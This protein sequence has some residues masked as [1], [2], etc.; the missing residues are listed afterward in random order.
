MK[1]KSA[2]ITLSTGEE[3]IFPEMSLKDF[4]HELLRQCE[5]ELK[6]EIPESKKL[7]FEIEARKAYLKLPKMWTDYEAYV[8][9]YVEK[10]CEKYFIVE[11]AKH[12]QHELIKE[13]EQKL[14]AVKP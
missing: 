4:A 13:Y 14:K 2:T 8:K 6:I 3:I 11:R 1:I 9:L 12:S 10:E 7:D 5:P